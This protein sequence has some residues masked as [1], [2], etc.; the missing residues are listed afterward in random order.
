MEGGESVGGWKRGGDGEFE[1]K[2]WEGE[3]CGGNRK[4]RGERIINTAKV[5]LYINYI[6]YDIIVV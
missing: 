5:A 3:C 6:I 4:A 1:R 2:L